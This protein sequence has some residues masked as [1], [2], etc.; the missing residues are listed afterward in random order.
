M[1]LEYTEP[2]GK[3]L[4]G[5]TEHGGKSCTEC[6]SRPLRSHSAFFAV[7]YAFRLAIRV[8]GPCRTVMSFSVK[9]F[10]LF[11]EKRVVAIEIMLDIDCIYHSELF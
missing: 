1:L 2:G 9:V 3:Y 7:R 11:R 8:A 4:V 5:Y 10:Q 6:S